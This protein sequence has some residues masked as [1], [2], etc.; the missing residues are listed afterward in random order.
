MGKALDI[1]VVAEG[2]NTQD[3]KKVLTQLGCEYFQG[4]HFAKPASAEALEEY[5]ICKPPR[6]G[7]Y[8]SRAHLTHNVS[9]QIQQGA[10][11]AQ[12]ICYTSTLSTTAPTHQGLVQLGIKPASLL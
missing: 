8:S 1:M 5:L 2:V 4:Y 3:Q 10:S 7:I 11:D 9:S 12:Q 6:I